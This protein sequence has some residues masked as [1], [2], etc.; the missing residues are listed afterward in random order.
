MKNEP[1]YETL[2]LKAK[3]SL[4]ANEQRFLSFVASAPVGIFHSD[5]NGTTVY[6]NDA[7]CAITGMS[8][9]EALE[10]D[11]VS[12]IHPNDR[13][14]TLKSWLEFLRGEAG[15]QREE[16]DVTFIKAAMEKET[17]VYGDKDRLMQV[18]LT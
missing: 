7:W 10:G 11:W 14:A 9:S 3:E 6:V 15:Y 4:R 5:L 13:E 17:L 2:Y 8:A 16:Y 1:D 18:W 12:A